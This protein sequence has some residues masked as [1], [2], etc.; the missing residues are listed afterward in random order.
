VPVDDYGERVLPPR[1]ADD[2]H[3][4]LTGA[5]DLQIHAGSLQQL[6]AVD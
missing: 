1:D 4:E 2:V 3:R 6:S 5:G